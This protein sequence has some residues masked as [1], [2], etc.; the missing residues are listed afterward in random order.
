MAAGKQ[1]FGRGRPGLLSKEEEFLVLDL[2]KHLRA[3]G[4]VVDSEIIRLL[5]ERVRQVVFLFFI[6]ITL[7]ITLLS[8][9]SRS[10]AGRLVTIYP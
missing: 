5:A 9:A 4:C 1:L 8:G 2:I 6:R 10:C 7:Y 3:D